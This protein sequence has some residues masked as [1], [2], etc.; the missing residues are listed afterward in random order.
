[1]TSI[2]T[3]RCQWEDETVRIVSLDTE[4]VIDFLTEPSV[5]LGGINFLTTESCLNRTIMS[6]VCD[7]VLK[8]I[9]D[10]ALTITSYKQIM[11]FNG[12][13]SCSAFY[14]RRLVAICKSS[15]EGL[16]SRC[17]TPWTVASLR[18]IR[19]RGGARGRWCTL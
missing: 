4:T 10:V 14:K 12:T 11:E 3:V 19:R 17:Q 1:M 7:T 13:I 6:T 5:G 9:I 8:T 16:P 2:L 18:R 15:S